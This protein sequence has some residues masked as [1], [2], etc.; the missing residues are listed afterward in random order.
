MTTGVFPPGPR[1]G[2]LS[3]FALRRNP[4]DFMTRVA[5]K[6]GPIVHLRVGKRHDYLLNRPDYIQKVLLA[7]EM[8]RSSARPLRRLLGQG[9]L[10]TTGD[11]HRAQRRT[12]QPLFHPQHIA[13][14][15]DVIVAAA[16]RT[17]ARWR[18]DATIDIAEAML[19]L[20]QAIIVKLAL[21]VESDADTRGLTPALRDVVEAVNKN[22]FP[23]LAA[24]FLPFP[25]PKAGMLER[26]S[27]RVDGI[28][29]AI[30]AERRASGHAGSD[31]L[32]EMLRIPDADGRAQMT[33]REL[34]DHAMTF[35]SAGHETIG[36]ALSWTWFLLAQHPAIEAEMHAELDEVLGGRLP[37]ADDVPRLRVVE[38][39]LKESMRLYPP[40][41]VV[42]R[43]PVEDWPL[44]DYVIPAGA[45]LQAC[46]YVTHRDPEYFEA[47][48]SFTPHRWL[49]AGA[50]TRYK[51]AYFPFAAGAYKC[52]GESLAWTEGILIIATLAQ[53]WAIRLVRPGYVAEPEAMITLRP[54]GG[55]P[56]TLR[57]RA[58]SAVA[59]A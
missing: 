45:Y 19:A 17:R 21:G 16:A 22:T 26:A 18:P 6:H 14:W 59:S 10:T 1:S 39:V 33:D 55:L 44:G 25:S 40:V 57:A 47:A 43:R 9:V 3:Y 31:M 29:A 12:L 27:T 34:R 50:A 4:L 36:N 46:P 11:V 35:M 41:W 30:I 28:L 13:H 2:L 58:S 56:M 7:P 42:A 38:A 48:G 15:G 49:A 53:A 8:S 23:S 37:N 32:T 54:K 20:S 24:L 51:S 5:R 52:I